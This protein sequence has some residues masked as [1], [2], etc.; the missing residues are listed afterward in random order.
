[1]GEVETAV[2]Q[3]DEDALAGVGLR[4]ALTIAC[5]HFVNLGLVAGDVGLALDLRTHVDK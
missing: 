3:S 1:M 5:E 4:Q 2:N